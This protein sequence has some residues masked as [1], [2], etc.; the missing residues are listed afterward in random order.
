MSEYEKLLYIKSV[1]QWVVRFGMTPMPADPVEWYRENIVS[2]DADFVFDYSEE[3]EQ[4]E[5]S[6]LDSYEKKEHSSED[7][8][9][10]QELALEIIEQHYG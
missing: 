9:N 4:D 3:D 6:L 2:T 8:A 1:H 5:L 10:S 7:S